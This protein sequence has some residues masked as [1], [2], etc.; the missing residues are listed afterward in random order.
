MKKLPIKR[1]LELSK[2]SIS[3]KKVVWGGGEINYSVRF[4]AGAE[5]KE[6]KNYCQELYYCHCPVRAICPAMLLHNYKL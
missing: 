1:V 4:M 5:S 6:G 2:E 3:I